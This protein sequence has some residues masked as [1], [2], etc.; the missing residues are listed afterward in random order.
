MSW[1]VTP[2][3]PVFVM[4]FPSLSSFLVGK[5]GH[6]RRNALEMTV[7]DSPRKDLTHNPTQED[8]VNAPLCG[9]P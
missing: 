7:S 2:Q 8:L 3:K 4:D 6:H 9:G 1:E 5:W